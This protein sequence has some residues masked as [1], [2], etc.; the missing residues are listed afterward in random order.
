[1]GLGGECPEVK[2]LGPRGGLWL[3]GRPKLNKLEKKGQGKI[4]FIQSGQT[5][6]HM[7][8]LSGSPWAPIAATVPEASHSRE[9]SSVWAG[10]TIMF[11]T[12]LQKQLPRQIQGT[13]GQMDGQLEE[14]AL[15]TYRDRKERSC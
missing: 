5:H 14:V 1:M 4:P 13:E 7:F 12:C 2:A 3:E 9:A 8:S 11:H 15:Q 6:A 10:P